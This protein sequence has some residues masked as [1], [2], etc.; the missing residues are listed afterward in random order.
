MQS[1]SACEV[2][3]PQSSLYLA[4]QRYFLNWSVCSYV[5]YRPSE[6]FCIVLCPVFFKWQILLN[7]SRLAAFNS[8]CITI[9][10]NMPVPGLFQTF[11]YIY[12]YIYICIKLWL[13]KPSMES[14]NS[15]NFVVWR[16]HWCGCAVWVSAVICVHACIIMHVYCVLCPTWSSE[17]GSTPVYSA[18]YFANELINLISSTTNC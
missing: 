7:S 5:I 2:I 8:T 17:R 10:K 3:N 11:I 1:W 13:H 15:N 14:P 18:L 12:I 6:R 4:T 9:S 16:S